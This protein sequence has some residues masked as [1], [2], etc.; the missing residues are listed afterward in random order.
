[1]DWWGWLIAGAVL[2]GAELTWVDAQFYLVFIGSAALLVGL[3]TG[4]HAAIS[5]WAQWLIFA[6]LC[7]V[8]M[9]GFRAKIYNRLRGHA[10]AVRSGPAGEML[11]L[12]AGLAP[13]QSCQA[14]HGGTF[15]TVR[16]DSELAIA[17]GARARIVAVQG[18]TLAVRPE[19]PAG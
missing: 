4:A 5:I 15:W 6:G 16:N 8:S 14:E 18:L 9:V 3:L 12:A 7:I 10:S 17:P 1:M 2:L 19:S 13:G 11:T